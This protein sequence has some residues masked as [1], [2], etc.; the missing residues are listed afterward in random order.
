MKYNMIIKMRGKQYEPEMRRLIIMLLCFIL[1]ATAI[2]TYSFRYIYAFLLPI[3]YALFRLKKTIDE[4]K[5]LTDVTCVIETDPKELK[6]TT[7]S[8][9]PKL[10]GEYIIPICDSSRFEIDKQC[11]I[12]IVFFDKKTNSIINLEFTGLSVDYEFWEMIA[13]MF[14]TKA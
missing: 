5:A 2:V 13:N 3:C 9:Q 1:A 10:C 12:S 8:A 14:I 11:R 6:L 4:K 7:Q